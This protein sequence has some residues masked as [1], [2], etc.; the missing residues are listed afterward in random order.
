M[1]RCAVLAP[2]SHNS[3]PWLF[4][5]TDDA[6]DLLADRTRALPV[7]EPD[8]R[9]LVMSCGAALA[10]LRVAARGLCR[11]PIVELLPDLGD[12]TSWPASPWPRRSRR[13]RRTPARSRPSPAGA[14]TGAATRRGR[15]PKGVVVRLRGAASACGAR[16]APVRKKSARLEVAKLVVAG[17]RIQSAD[18]RFRRELAAWMHPRRRGDG[19]P[20][21]AAPVAQLIVRTFDVGRSTAARNRQLAAGS[22]LLAVLGTDEDEPREWL[23]AGQAV[24]RVLLLARASDVW[25]SFLNQPIEVPKLRPLLRELVPRRGHPQ[26]LLRMGYGP[27]VPP[28][29]RRPLDDVLVQ[30]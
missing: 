5:L 23:S 8:D 4:R 13:P 24:A 19:I 17:D 20:M 1:V 18:P 29:P 21:P 27:D 26:L 11:E 3:Q 10:H 14:P 15:C 30:C 22:P 28:T 2:S 25:C 6:L 16:L 7:V 12:P 9:G